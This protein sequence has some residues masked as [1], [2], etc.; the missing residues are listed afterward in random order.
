MKLTD[1]TISHLISELKKADFASKEDFKPLATKTDVK[2]NRIAIS[3]L[4]TK[5]TKLDTKI[6]KLD[7]K[8]TKL[9]TKTTKLDTKITRLDTKT[10]KIDTKITRLDKKLDQ[11]ETVVAKG[12]QNHEDRIQS[13]ESFHPAN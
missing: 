8:I 1:I 3:E 9:D 11:L 6:T 5:T 10:T 2:K 13:L 12:S 4:D 7:T